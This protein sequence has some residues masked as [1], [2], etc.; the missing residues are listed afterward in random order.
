[1]RYGFRPAALSLD[2]FKPPHP[3]LEAKFKEFMDAYVLAADGKTQ[4][5]GGS[6]KTK[7]GDNP[8]PQSAKAEEMAYWERQWKRR[9]TD[10]SRL[11][12]LA[13]MQKAVARLK[14]AP[15]VSTRR[16]TLEWRMAIAY[17]ERTP[18]EVMA[19]YDIG[20]TTYYDCRAELNPERPKRRL[21]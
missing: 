10:R 19:T 2:D 7:G 4:S 12:L 21:R 8:V 18:A 20:R 13:E 3:L 17:D 16:G 11:G 9:K 5:Y 1:M 6:N 14:F 15:H